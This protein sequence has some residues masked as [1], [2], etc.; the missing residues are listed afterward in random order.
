MCKLDHILIIVSFEDEITVCNYSSVSI[1]NKFYVQM[2][3]V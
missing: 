1:F 3:I 2:T